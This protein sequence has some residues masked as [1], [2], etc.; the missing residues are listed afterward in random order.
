GEETSTVSVTVSRD[1]D[2][3]GASTV[4]YATSNGNATSGTCGSGSSDY[5][6]SSGTLTF[7][8]SVT[9][10]RFVVPLCGDMI[11]ENP[12][13]TVNLTLSSAS[14]G[15]L[16]GPDTATLDIIDAAT[17]FVNNTLITATPGNSSSPYPST[18]EVSGFKQNIAR[19]RVTL[20]NVNWAT[21]NTLYGLLIGP[22]GQNIVLIADVGGNFPLSGSTITLD[23]VATNFMPANNPIIDGQNY[24]PT[25]CQ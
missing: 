10:Q 1:G 11:T 9:S 25:T 22:G 4:A 6:A 12:A 14:G 8:P 16:G 23:D 17:Q 5:V 18:I 2:L 21:S 24:R 13:E 3:S 15:T 19:L 7:A 20:F